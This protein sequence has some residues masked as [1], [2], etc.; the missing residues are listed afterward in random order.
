MWVGKRKAH[1]DYSESTIHH[2]FSFARR[3]PAVHQRHGMR[4]DGRGEIERQQEAGQGLPVGCLFVARPEGERLSVFSLVRLR[5]H[6]AAA[7]HRASHPLQSGPAA[8]AGGYS[9]ARVLPLSGERQGAAMMQLG[10]AIR[11]PGRAR[12]ISVATRPFLP[13]GPAHSVPLPPPALPHAGAAA[14]LY[15][16][17]PHFRPPRRRDAGGKGGASAGGRGAGGGG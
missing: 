9:G 14:A 10:H 13:G 16:V 12:K 17:R 8:A 2:H 11:K 6:S 7:A 5:R 4:P 15:S 3:P 1:H